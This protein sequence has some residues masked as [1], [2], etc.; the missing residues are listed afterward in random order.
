VSPTPL[1]E[2]LADARLVH[3]DARVLALHLLGDPRFIPVTRPVMTAIR[4]GGI[5]AQTSAL[6]LYQIL[7]ELYRAGKSRLASD[8]GRALQVHA[9]L[10]VVSASPQISAQAAEV[11]AQ[12]GGK[13]ER[14]LQIATALVQG[15][16]IYLTTESGLRRIVGMRIVNLE[17]EL[18]PA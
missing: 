5:Q 1:I 16:D 17:D 15:A 7:A 18:P 2:R 3:V 9:G 14:A 6:T 4:E 12:L 8:V 13:P 10:E 11:R